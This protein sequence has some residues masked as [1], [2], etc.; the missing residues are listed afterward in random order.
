MT[1]SKLIIWE[2]LLFVLFFFRSGIESSGYYFISHEV[3][4]T[5]HQLSACLSLWLSSLMLGSFVC[6]EDKADGR[7]EEER[8]VALC[9]TGR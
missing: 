2:R 4:L 1:D 7:E 5:L 6:A 8:K 3:S 9:F